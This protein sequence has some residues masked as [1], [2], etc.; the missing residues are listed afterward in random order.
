MSSKKAA[1]VSFDRSPEEQKIA[2]AF[3]ARTGPTAKRPY[4]I[5]YTDKDFPSLPTRWIK[6][7]FDTEDECRDWI[8]VNGIPCW[9]YHIEFHQ[10]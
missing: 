5:R 10:T 3:L 4:R 6:G 9:N 2:R 7:R 1:V 8:K